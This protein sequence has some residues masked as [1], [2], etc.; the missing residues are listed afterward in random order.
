MRPSCFM[1]YV[2]GEKDRMGSSLAGRPENR[3][4]ARLWMKKLNLVAMLPRL[5]S[6]SL[7]R[8]GEKAEE[9]KEI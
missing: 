2:L 6:I 4:W 3:N 1:V 7:R 8:G 5:D 9:T